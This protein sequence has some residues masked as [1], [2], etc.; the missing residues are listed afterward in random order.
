MNI[1]TSK[2]GLAA[3][4][5]TRETLV[6]VRQSD[7]TFIFESKKSLDFYEIEYLNSCCNK[8]DTELMSLRRLLTRGD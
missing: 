7:R 2:L 3:Y 4:I 5:K 8:H 1:Q 6:E